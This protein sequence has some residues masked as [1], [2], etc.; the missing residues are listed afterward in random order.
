MKT[1]ILIRLVLAIHISALAIMAGTT[2]ID[3]VTFRTFWERVDVEGSEARG[4]LP[5]MSKYGSIVRASGAFLLISG[6]AM[7][8]LVDGVWWQQLWFKVKMALVLLLLL[9]G[10]IIGNKNGVAFRE[11]A[12][13]YAPDFIDQSAEVRVNL[14]R[15][16]LTQ[17]FLFFAI[18]LVSAIKFDNV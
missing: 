18:I 12:R 5:I 6:I 3:Y 1:Y 2:V 4:L 7:L 13:A 9:N 8:A 10:A 16:Y 17:L 11:L 14:N 15:F